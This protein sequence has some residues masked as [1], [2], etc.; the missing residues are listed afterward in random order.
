MQQRTLA[1]IYG[2]PWF[3]PSTCSFQT[4]PDPRAQ[5][6]VD[7]GQFQVTHYHKRD[8]TREHIFSNQVD[9]I[10]TELGF[11]GL[12]GR[13]KWM[14]GQSVY[15]LIY[16][17]VLSV[18]PSTAYPGS[19]IRRGSNRVSYT[20]NL[21]SWLPYTGGGRQP[22]KESW[23]DPGSRATSQVPVSEPVVAFSIWLDM[24]GVSGVPCGRLV[25]HGGYMC[26]PSCHRKM[27]ATLDESVE[28]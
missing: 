27:Q 26:P 4:T 14:D 15:G 10:Y 12:T 23:R 6:Q 16:M 11:I 9:S 22:I 19:D 5:S 24:A 2:I 25:A 21:S 7:R 8:W 18:I 28:C 13:I 1:A 20:V 3:R 17:Y